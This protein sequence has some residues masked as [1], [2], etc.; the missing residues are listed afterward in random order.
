MEPESLKTD[1]AEFVSFRKNHLKGDEKGEGQVFLDRLFK[2][3]GLGGVP[4]AGATLEARVRSPEDKKIS[5]ADL[6]WKPRCIIEMKKAG[7]DLSKHYPQAF[8]YWMQAVPDRPRYVALCNFDEF[9]VYD[10]DVQLD[11][12]MD[13]LRL[14]DLAQRREVLAFLLPVPEEPIFGNDL[15]KVTREAAAQVA[16]V[17]R[18]MYERGIDRV[19]AQHFVLQSVVAMFAEDIGLLPGKFFARTVADSKSGSEAYDLL[20]SLFREMNTQGRTKGGKFANTPYFNGGL[21][22]NVVPVEMTSDELD[23][24][25]TASKTDW[26]AV[27]PEIFG[28]LF[29]RSMDQGERHAYGAHFTSQAD[30]ARVVIPCIVDPWTERIEAAKTID[31][32]GRIRL[33]MA[34]F[35]VLD[36]ACGSGNFLYVAYREMRRLEAKVKTRITERRRSK[37]AGQLEI[38]W[39]TPDH[40]LGLDNNQFAVEVAKVTMMMAKKLAADELDEHIDALPLDNLD[41]TIRWADALFHP[42]PQANVI[43]G[44]PPYNGRRKMVEDLG[45]DYTQRLAQEYPNIGGVSDYVSYWFPLAHQA[46]PK[47]GR[48]GF[49]ATQAIRDGD[50]RKAS[51]DYVVDH[52]GVIFD[53]VS[54]MPWSG[55]A[56]VHVSIVNWI[57][58]KESAP[59]GAVL[60]LDKGGL[61]LTVSHIPSTLRPM[62]DV[63]KAAKLPHNLIPKKCFQG[64]TSGHVDG[65]RLTTSEAKKLIS[66]NSKLREVV[67]PTISG[68][69]LIHSNSVPGYVI[70]IGERDLVKANIDYPQVMKLLKTRV[71][72]QRQEAAK[73]EQKRNEELLAKNPN[74]KT[75]SV[76]QDFLERSWW[77]HWRRREDMLRALHQLDRYIALVRT[78]AEGRRSIY[79]FIDSDIRPDDSLQVFAFDD[80]YAFGVLSSSLHRAWFDE[81]CSRLKVDPRYTST[82][83]WDTFP[84]PSSPTTVQVARIAGISAEILNLRE[85]YRAQGLTLGQ[86]YDL[87]RD[88]GKSDFRDAHEAL[89]TAVVEAYGFTPDDDLLAQLL[90]L[91]L[92]AASDPEVATPPGSGGLA[93]AYTTSYRLIA[94]QL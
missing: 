3:F 35:R 41:D 43:I 47:G 93:E 88:S 25:R 1:L 69:P 46:L 5:F 65:F 68:D 63:A 66:Q 23:A 27:R 90:A 17:F 28:T 42:W 39:V 51:L 84:W 82:T 19:E 72:P 57:K 2:A 52:D 62:T 7:T 22:Q 12:P 87:L 37:S 78:A 14:D 10:F 31:E 60:W 85:C 71:L 48:A 55:D 64:Q 15:V 9:L 36:P 92:A 4:E 44:N 89:D 53:A 56:V 29:E 26:S 11:E 75:V 79:Q 80:D 30:I 45:L 34:N 20:G 38:S 40:F 77:R 54:V 58:G 61:R 91:N 70:D 81:R 24:M 33:E 50:T 59:D 18:S 13:R 67:L 83:V 49:V 86:Q 73:T 74:G 21:F 6:V 94:Q 32:L 8:K 16:G 76:R